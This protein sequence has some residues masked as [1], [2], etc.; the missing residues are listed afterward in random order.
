MEEQQ[1]MKTGVGMI[2]GGSMPYKLYRV[3]KWQEWKFRQ[4]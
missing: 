3:E 4:G 2:R 1:I